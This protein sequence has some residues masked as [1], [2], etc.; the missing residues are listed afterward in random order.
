MPDLFTP[1]VVDSGLSVRLVLV[2]GF[3]RLS[4]DLY[5]D[6]DCDFDLNYRDADFAGDYP[7]GFYRG[8][9]AGRDFAADLYFA[10]D[11]DFVVDRVFDSDYRDA[12]FADGYPVGCGRYSGDGRHVDSVTAVCFSACAFYHFSPACA[13]LPAQ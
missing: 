2:D 12:D 8:F 4:A 13:N 10:V 3:G 1:V 7:A 11:R 9:V 6:R 5:A